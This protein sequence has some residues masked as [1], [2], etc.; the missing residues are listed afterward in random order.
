MLKAIVSSLLVFLIPTIT[1]AATIH[2]VDVPNECL[3]SL[4]VKK[5]SITNTSSSPSLNF[6]KGYTC[7]RL[8][9]LRTGLFVNEIAKKTEAEIKAKLD[10]LPSLS[11][12]IKKDIEKI[13]ADIAGSRKISSDVIKDILKDT[14]WTGIGIVEAVL[15]CGNP[16]SKNGCAG[17]SIAVIDGI[18]ETASSISNGVDWLNKQK[19]LKDQLKKAN[20]ELKKARDISASE[21]KRGAKQ[22]TIDFVNICQIIKS[23]CK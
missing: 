7:E 20:E 16:A 9:L 11:E 18:Y 22:A 1:L 2:G 19:S 21:I 15:A 4:Q 17:A 12:H 13:E 5:V 14:T 3:S 23:N 8:E 6:L 10:S